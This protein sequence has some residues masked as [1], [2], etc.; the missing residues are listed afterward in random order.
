VLVAGGNVAAVSAQAAKVAGVSRV[1]TV[2]NK[3]LD[4]VVAENMTN[5]LKG[6]A[7]NY[8][9]VLAASNNSGKNYMPRLGAVL[10]VAPISDVLEVVNEST[11]KRPM[12]AGN[13][14]STVTMSDPVKLILV[15]T[16]AFEKAAATGGSAAVEA[17]AVADVD[18][19]KSKFVSSNVSVSA[20]PELTAAKI[21]VSGGRGMKSAENFKLLE[22]LADKVG[23]AVGA[24]RAAVDAGY[25]PNELQIGQ[26]GKVVAPNLYIAVSR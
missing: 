4:A 14:I 3:V 1:L 21:V 18:A 19:G 11:F 16:T 26:T 2:E 9:H 24:S 15:R 7:K 13:A 17:L 25:A 22:T 23:G 6:I 8:T 20:R 10:D 5:V 12:Y